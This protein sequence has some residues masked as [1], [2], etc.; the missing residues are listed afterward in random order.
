MT[1]I[2]VAIARACGR[3]FDVNF[4]VKKLSKKNRARPHQSSRER[5]HADR[6]SSEITLEL[7]DRTQQLIGRPE[8]SA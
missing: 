8:P 6:F 2:L 7:P 4:Y 3:N 5:S 1:M